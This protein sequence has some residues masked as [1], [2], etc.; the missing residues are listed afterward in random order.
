[1]NRKESIPKI[2]ML[3]MFLFL[4]GIRMG[5]SQEFP[6]S[7]PP[8]VQRSA[9]IPPI[10]PGNIIDGLPRYMAKHFVYPRASWDS[11]KLN[12]YVNPLVMMVIHKDGSVS[13]V[14]VYQVTDS[15]LSAEVARALMGT[16]WYPATTKGHPV[17][18]L[19]QITVPLTDRNTGLP[20]HLSPIVSKVNAMNRA[21]KEYKRG[22]TVT[23][24]SERMEPYKE[25]C[26]WSASSLNAT[27]PLST[28]LVTQG[29][30]AEAATLLN[31][32]LDQYIEMR[33]RYSDWK[34][35][36]GRKEL[37]ATTLLALLKAGAKAIDAHAAIDRALMLIDMKIVTGNVNRLL[38]DRER[39]I[40]D[41][42]IRQLMNEQVNAVYGTN[43][44]RHEESWQRPDNKG[45]NIADDSRSIAY[46]LDH[47]YQLPVVASQNRALMKQMWDAKEHGI[48]SK[49]VL[50]ELLG[51]RALLIC[52]TEGVDSA[53]AFIDD[54]LKSS[55]VGSKQKKYMYGIAEKVQTHRQVLAD[56]SAVL[57]SLASYAPLNN[58]SLTVEANKQQ[59]RR[60]YDTRKILEKV[61]PIRWL[62]E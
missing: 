56:R 2:L 49:N 50:N 55:E 5:Y 42:F 52:A 51:V 13:N 22:I 43:V 8:G 25:L 15:I 18:V 45:F 21:R 44:D 57:T 46:F 53:M 20:F 35:Y 4:F 32:G 23:D 29:K 38:T 14:H 33:G 61:F 7:L 3:S 31:R 16:R 37:A 1:M 10:F 48:K 11:L 9:D 59:A 62:M 19:Y 36:S 30:W 27:M 17:D 47:G 34:G 58:A 60:F 40:A 12:G 6:D 26:F 28:M 41:R 54:L 39:E 24:L